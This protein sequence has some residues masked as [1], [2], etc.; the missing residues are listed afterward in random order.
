MENDVG[1]KIEITRELAQRLAH[2]VGVDS[3]MALMELRELLATPVAEPKVPDAYLIEGFRTSS[4]AGMGYRDRK[5]VDAHAETTRPRH[6]AYEIITMEYRLEC[7]QFEADVVW[8]EA[9][10]SPLYR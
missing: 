2:G 3:V 8:H 4:D 5:I 1:G 10:L 7:N 9:K 6:R